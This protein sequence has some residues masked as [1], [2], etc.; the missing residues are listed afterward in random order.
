MQSLK[1]LKGNIFTTNCQTLVNTVN[2]VGVMGAGIALEFKLRYPDMDQKYI[3]LCQQGLLDIGKLWIYKTTS[4]WI[5][6]FPTKKH[7]KN[8]SKE[9]YLHAGLQKFLETYEEKE[10]HSIAFPLLGA[11]HGGIHPEKSLEIMTSYLSKCS[12]SVEIYQHDPHAYD[13]LCEHTRDLFLTTPINKLK[14]T[15]GLT[16]SQINKLSGIF[17]D[18]SFTQL[19]HLTKVKGISTKT[20]EKVFAFAMKNAD[21]KYQDEQQKL[22]LHV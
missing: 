10:I 11:Q 12:I 6:N 2:C 15:T 14:L 13:D 21:K 4:R 18:S 8:P 20:L 9:S 3:S 19:N 5:L 22:S 16:P 7:W 1:I 17:N